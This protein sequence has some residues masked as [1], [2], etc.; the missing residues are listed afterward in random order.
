MHIL[1]ATHNKNKVMEINSMMT[2]GLKLLSLSDVGMHTEIPE[3]GKTIKEN[4]FL[5]AKAANEFLK[6]Q[7]KQ[8]SVFADDSGLEVIALSAAPGVNS[9]RYAGEER[10]DEKNNR[11]LLLELKN[12][13]KR[14]ARFVT[15]ITLLINEEIFFFEGEIKGTEIKGPVAVEASEKYPRI[16]NLASMV[17]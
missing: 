12:I 11:K 1:F 5:K 16:A 15:I 2:N 14:N 7:N 6:T 10:D 17:V 8:M 13:T 9:A 3:T 4:S